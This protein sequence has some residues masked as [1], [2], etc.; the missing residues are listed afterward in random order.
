MFPG[1]YH[2]TAY[3]REKV[4]ERLTANRD[5]HKD[6]VERAR[7]AYE[8]LML[9]ELAQRLDDAKNGTFPNPNFL[10]HLPVPVD[11][12]REYERAIDRFESQIDHEVLLT[13]DEFNKYMRD[14][15]DWSERFAASNATY[16]VS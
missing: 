3:Q 1:E 5:G 2:A 10:Q 9:N 4:L 7:K 11:Y 15:W 12:T 13:D 8:E 14:E 6:K 16:N